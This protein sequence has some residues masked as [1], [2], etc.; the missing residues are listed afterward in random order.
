MSDFNIAH[1]I[2]EKISN[3]IKKVILGN[4]ETIKKIL[5]AFFF[6]S[7]IL[8][9]D[10]PGTGKTTLAK[11]LAKSFDIDFKRIQFTPDLLPAD[12]LGVSIFNKEKG[13]F[14]FQKG[15]IFTNIL[16]ADE[17][18]RANPRTQSA[19]LE[20]M[21]ENKI[22]IEGKE[23]KLSSPFFVI[24]TENPLDFQGTYPLPESQIDRFAMRLTPGYVDKETEVKILLNRIKSDP[25]NEIQ[26]VCNATDVL[27]VSNII[28]N[29]EISQDII[30]Y[31]VEIVTKTRNF[32]NIT[33]G[34]S[35]RT[36]IYL[37]NISRSTAFFEGRNFVVPE[38]VQNIAK[39]IISHRLKL[40]SNAV[41]SGISAQKTVEKILQTIKVP[42]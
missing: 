13:T 42:Q 36:S 25:M 21:S 31:I 18:N 29:V 1:E 32:E 12:I 10:V 23:Y 9:E 35:P 16:L 19:L 2:Y 33:L 41:F 20:A 14:H 11:V 27:F 17:I 6:N 7:H 22:T 4:D 39:D 3:N 28:K 34:A 30:K 15:P 37:M 5:S 8:L 24:A 26:S 40:D 38:D